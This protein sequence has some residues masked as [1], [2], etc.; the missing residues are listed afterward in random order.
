[1]KRLVFAKTVTCRLTTGSN[2]YT[3]PNN[4]PTR[5]PRHRIWPEGD[6]RGENYRE[7][8]R[9]KLPGKFTGGKSPGKSPASPGWTGC[10]VL[11]RGVSFWF[12][13][14]V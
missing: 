6:H 14:P 4:N 5:P 7:N 8:L 3:N 2:D 12:L 13:T 11:L 9:G 10:C 1:M